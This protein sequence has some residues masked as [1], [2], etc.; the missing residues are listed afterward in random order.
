MARAY[1]L[2]AIATVRSIDNSEHF[3]ESRHNVLER[4]DAACTTAIEVRWRRGQVEPALAVRACILKR[5]FR[6]GSHTPIELD[7]R[8]DGGIVRRDSKGTRD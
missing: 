2:F 6:E 4:D 8:F 5:T 3:L 7:F 1:Q